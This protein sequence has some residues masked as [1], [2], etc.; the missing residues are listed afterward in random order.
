MAHPPAMVMVEWL[1][2]HAGIATPG[3]NASLVITGGAV[4]GVAALVALRELTDEDN[5]RRASPFVALVP[6]VLWWQTADAFFAGVAASAATLIILASGR[7]GRRA[8]LYAVAG[9]LLFGFALFLSYGIA[10]LGLLPVAVC[11]TRR[12]ARPLALAALGTV[13]WFLG[14]ATYG[15]SWFA[16]F[17]ATRHQYWLAGGAA[18]QRPYTYFVVADLAVFAIA[19]GPAVTVAITRIRDPRLWSLVGGILTIVALADLSGMSK[20]EVERI[21]LPFVPWAMLAT[22]QLTDDA[23]DVRETRT[24]L[25]VQLALTIVLAIAIPSRW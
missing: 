22:S 15:F 14:F 4:A 16:G 3:W 17:A 2:T 8:D 18:S 9:G 13:P 1:L 11:V 10:L 20:G 12:K 19:T 24:W 5:A 7:Q 6:A 21:W 25:A 23:D